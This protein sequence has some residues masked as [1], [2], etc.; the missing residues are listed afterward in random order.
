M[1]VVLSDATR[2]DGLTHKLKNAAGVAGE[3]PIGTPQG[4]VAITYVK[5]HEVEVQSLVDPGADI[6]TI[7]ARCLGS[8]A[9]TNEFD[10]AEMNIHPTLFQN[11]R[12]ANDRDLP[13]MGAV[14]LPVK[15]NGRTVHVEFQI[16]ENQTIYP[17]ILG[18]NCLSRL[19]YKLIDAVDGKDLLSDTATPATKEA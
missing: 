5:I 7:S 11:C 9:K 13:L 10:L 15:R 16:P 19:G 3:L 4:N 12:T 8:I 6:S 17:I 18:T 2:D 1:Q 14:T